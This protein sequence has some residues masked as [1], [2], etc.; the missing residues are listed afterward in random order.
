VVDEGN[1]QA[2]KHSYLQVPQGALKFEGLNKKKYAVCVSQDDV[3]SLGDV[4]IYSKAGTECEL[5][6]HEGYCKECD[7]PNGTGGSYGT[8]GSPN[9]SGGGY[10]NG[11]CPNYPGTCDSPGNSAADID[12]YP[13]RTY[14]RSCSTETC[15]IVKS[16]K[17]LSYIAVDAEKCGKYPPHVTL[18]EVYYGRL[19]KKVDIYPKWTSG[20]D[21]SCSNC[22]ISVPEG[23]LK[24]EGLDKSQYAVCVTHRNFESPGDIKMIAKSGTTC[25]ANATCSECEACDPHECP[26]M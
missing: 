17:E 13:L 12:F 6:S 1:S 21:S 5:E 14:D 18:H 25:T 2:C 8:G 7:E 4:D 11:E 24:F 16:S 19:G 26:E 20:N 10:G 23:M 22:T 3:K 9:G 15:T